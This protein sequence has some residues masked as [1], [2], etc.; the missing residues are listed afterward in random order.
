M[1]HGNEYFMQVSRRIVN[2][3]KYKGLS[4]NAKW[5]YVVLKEL[6]Q[7]FCGG[8]S[9]NNFFLRSDRQLAEDTGMSLATLKRAKAELVTTDL[10]EIRI[11]WYTSGGRK[12]K[13]VTSYKL[14]V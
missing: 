3:S 10:A 9:N 4:I 14:L 12:D 6:E 2:D 8:Q 7:R 13:H 11:G 5:L 1:K